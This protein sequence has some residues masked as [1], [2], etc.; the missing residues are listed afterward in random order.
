M[1]YV[2]TKTIEFSKL[3]PR[4]RKG[5]KAEIHGIGYNQYVDVQQMI[6]RAKDGPTESD[7]FKVS[8]DAN[9]IF[10]KSCCH[11]LTLDGVTIEPTEEDIA[12]LDTIY[13]QSL[14]N[15]VL[16]FNGYGDNE[17]N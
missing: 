16:D 9:V 11:S 8:S 7:R 3:D 15:E 4:A 5:D 17:K 12:G 1:G 6:I 10:V 13:Y 2:R 14:L